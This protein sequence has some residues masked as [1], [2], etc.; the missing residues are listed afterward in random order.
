MVTNFANVIGQ[1]PQ[2]DIAQNL[3]NINLNP[4]EIKTAMN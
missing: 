3:A 4:E 2:N 1:I